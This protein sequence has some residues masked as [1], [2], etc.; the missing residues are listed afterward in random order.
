M[1]IGFLLALREQKQKKDSI[2]QKKNAKSAWRI[3]S[4]AFL[5]PASVLYTVAFICLQ[6]SELA[7]LFTTF[8]LIK[9]PTDTSKYKFQ[10]WLKKFW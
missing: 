7:A 9:I 3:L 1:T 5:L 6:P 10:L 2:N 8:F 4:F